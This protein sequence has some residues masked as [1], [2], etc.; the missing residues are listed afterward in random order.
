MITPWA[1]TCMQLGSSAELIR[2]HQRPSELIRVHQSSSGAIRA[3][4]PAIGT[5]PP[6]GVDDRQLAAGAVARV[7]AQD[8]AS[9]HG[10]LEKQITQI[11]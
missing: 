4:Q 8:D 6:L 7:D 10:P 1:R 9:T 11:R 3:H 2:A 5:H